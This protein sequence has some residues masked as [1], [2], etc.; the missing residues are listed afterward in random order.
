[1]RLQWQIQ[2]TVAAKPIGVIDKITNVRRSFSRFDRVGEK[3]TD[4]LIKLN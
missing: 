1:M 3:A 4:H 2:L